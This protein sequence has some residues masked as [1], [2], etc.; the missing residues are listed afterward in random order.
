[1]KLFK[2]ILILFYSFLSCRPS[3][4]PVYSGPTII[5]STFQ[6]ASDSI[7]TDTRRNIDDAKK[8]REKEL[9]IWKAEQPFIIAGLVNVKQIIPS[10]LID[11]RYSGLN[12]FMDTDVYGDIA[13]AY[14]QPDVTEK[15][16][17]AQNALREKHPGYNLIIYDAARPLRVQ[18][19]MWDSIKVPKG[20]KTKYLSN[21]Q[22]GSLHNYGAAVDIGIAD[23][24]GR[25][26]DMGTPYDFFG[27]EASPRREAAMLA[28]GKLTIVHVKNRQMLRDIMYKAGFFNIQTEWWHF[29]AC[30]LENA[31]RS[32]KLIE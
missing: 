14:L 31:A 12:N 13:N 1:M 17:K 2:Y 25:E 6:V 11:L 24:L 29:N 21:P 32:Y 30:T 3:E 10:V 5:I 20:E 7:L 18:Q 19:L 16:A 22:Y 23:S 4:S 28:E 26:L 15:L 27:E 9:R 8:E